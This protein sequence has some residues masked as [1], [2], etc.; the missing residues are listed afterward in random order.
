MK[1]TALYKQLDH[2]LGVFGANIG[3]YKLTFY[4]AQRLC[5]IVG[6]TLASY[7]QLYKAWEAGMEWCR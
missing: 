3:R 1:I 7:D 5:E 2:M 6:A 4:E